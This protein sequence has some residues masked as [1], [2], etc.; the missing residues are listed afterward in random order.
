MSTTGQLLADVPSGDICLGYRPLAGVPDELCA[1]DGTP[2]AHW[3]RTWGLFSVLGLPELRE[4]QGEAQRLLRDNGVTYNVYGDPEGLTR[5]WKL[6]LVPLIIGAEEWARIERGLNQRA[7]LLNLILV[8]LYGRR[9]LIADGL[10]PHELVFTHQGLMRPWAGVEQPGPR[11]LALYAADLVRGSD[12][13]LRV[14]GDRTQSPSGAGYTLENRIASSRVLPGLFRDVHVQRLAEYFR[15][16]RATLAAMAPRTKDSPRTVVLSPGPRNELYFEHAYLASY[17]GYTL[18]EGGDLSVR[19]G[20]V[21]LLTLEGLQAVDVILRRVDDAFCDPLELREDSALG[22]PGL[23]EAVRNRQVSVANPIGSA[24]LENPGLMPYLPALSR[25]L[26]DADLLLP[27]AATWWCGTASGKS[28]VL[29][30]LE[31][32]VIKG[33]HRSPGGPSLVG[34][35]LSAAERD[36]LTRR[37]HARPHLYVGQELVQ[38]STVPV[39][40]DGRLEPRHAVVRAFLAAGEDDYAVMP[41]GLTRVSAETDDLI[42]ASQRGG[43]SKDTWVIA[44]APQHWRS[45]LP[46]VRSAPSQFADGVAALPSRV[47]DNLFWLGRYAERAE[48]L[49][50]LLRVVFLHLTDQFGVPEGECEPCLHSL[51]RTVTVQTG[52][53]WPGFL[54]PG[55]DGQPLQQEPELTELIANPRRTGSLAADLDALLDAARVVRDRLS[56]DTWRVIDDIEVSQRRLRAITERRL[57]RAVDELDRLITALLAFGGMVQENM[58]HCAGWRFLDIGR[59]LERGIHTVQLLQ[60]TVVPAQEERLQTILN[61]AMLRVLDSLITYRRR[62]RTTA[63]VACALD[64]VLLD[65]SNPR[66]VIYQLAA[67]ERQVMRLP[68]GTLPR[69]RTPAARILLPALTALRMADPTTLEAVDA[70]SQTRAELDRLLVATLESLPQVSEA[71]TATYFRHA[72]QPQQ[73]NPTSG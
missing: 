70:L 61:E 60:T 45:L 47:A 68:R 65:E 25:R 29:A 1:A 35:R 73:L 69:Y 7:E 38:P 40:A 12:G 14:L 23:I 50:R 53:T 18:V 5:P 32:L 11:Q 44:D 64:L 41:G 71:L 31:R 30:N 55:A 26:L 3:Q 15:R 10:L 58:T 48:G 39:L 34:A 21:K 16:L 57:P 72:E 19:A 22:V 20:A 8:D 62:Y 13:T 28:H 52:G 46:T 36:A 54:T 37:I 24:V 2:R 59:R 4:R 6:D 33:I 56:V 43:L 9:R 42:V 27:S 49:V 66:S 63:D 17:L 51:L 67:I